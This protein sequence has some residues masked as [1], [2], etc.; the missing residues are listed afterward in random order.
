[1]DIKEEIRSY[2]EKRIYADWQEIERHVSAPAQAVKDALGEMERDYELA[3]TKHG[4]YALASTMGLFHGRLECKAAGFGFLRTTLEEG[5]IFIPKSARE[6]A[7]DGDEVLVRLKKNQRGGK[8]LEGAVVKILSPVEVTVVGQL[9]RRGK[10]F[11]VRSS[12]LHM[13]DVLVA[14]PK[15]G[16]RP[17]G[18]I[19]VAKITKRGSGKHGPKGVIT[20]VLGK[21]GEKGVDIL[22]YARRFGL[23]ASFEKEC[24]DEAAEKKGKKRSPAGRLDLRK[25]LVFTIDGADAQDLDDAVSLKKL[26]GGQCELGVHIADVSHYVRENSALDKE[27]LRRGTSVYLVDR[28][29][30]M[31][32]EDLSNG[33]CSLHPGE[34]K[35][36]L[37][38]IMRINKH[39]DV[40]KYSL[41]RSIIRSQYRMTYGDV[42]LILEGDKGVCKQ[43]KALVKPLRD[44]NKLAAKLRKRRFD[45]GSVD[46]DLDEAQ[47]ILDKKGFPKDVVL[48]DRKDAEKLIEEFMLRAN[49]TVAEHFFEI[50]MPFLYRIHEQPDADRM[51]ELAI[52]LRNFGIKMQGVDD[53]Q[54]KAIQ[55]VLNEV[56]GTPEAGIVNNVTLRSLKKARYDALPGQ[57]FGLAAEQYCHFTSPIRRYPDLM[58]HRIIK[59]TLSSKLTVG[60]IEKLKKNLPEI[61]T[62]CSNRERNAIEAERAVEDLKMAEYMSRRIGKE[63]EGIVS[64]VTG[65]GVFVALPNTIEGMVSLASLDDDYY[66]YNEK[67]YCVVGEHTARRITLGD[68]ARVRVVAVD[69]PLGK[70]E[71]ELL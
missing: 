57:H 37:S 45:K 65:F 18:D 59:L 69:V 50:G 20:E 64:G 1:M 4:K 43:Y 19:V 29:V 46:F 17:Q 34:D 21:A 32:P 60:K 10:Q 52:F 12:A 23:D 2:V 30:P 68:K 48:R 9:V 14:P 40:V 25:E 6:G 62:Q 13:E 7:L 41:K 58:V 67:Q 47:I 22:A 26:P 27:A 28:V 71:F 63:Y 42:N 56:E 35:Y 36:T 16:G 54:P 31:L 66:V 8:N 49:I 39:G 51:K 53:V 15:K 3:Q 38:C 5:D 61:A 11:Y 33:L 55:Q 24:L 44:M 70:I